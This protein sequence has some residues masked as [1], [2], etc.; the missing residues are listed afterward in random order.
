ME[1]SFHIYLSSRDSESTFPENSAS[2]FRCRLQDRLPLSEAGWWCALL[3]LRLPQEIKQPLYICSDFCD[4]T[5]VGEFKLPTLALI[6]DQVTHP[7]HVIYVP[8]KT[9]ELYVIHLY[10]SDRFGEKISLGSGTSYCTLRICNYEGVR[11]N[12]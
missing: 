1:N 7:N 9:K 3:E 10:L 12:T 11:N 2:S 4:S 5:I 8:V 6:T